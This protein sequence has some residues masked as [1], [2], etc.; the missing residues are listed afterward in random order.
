MIKAICKYYLMFPPIARKAINVSLSGFMTYA[1]VDYYHSDPSH[2]LLECDEV[3]NKT[4]C[5]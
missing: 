1:G 5:I 2:V 3:I 4:L